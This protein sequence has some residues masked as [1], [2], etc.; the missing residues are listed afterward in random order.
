MWNAHLV[1]LNALLD[2]RRDRQLLELRR[3]LFDI[4]AFLRLGVRGRRV[5]SRE[6]GKKRKILMVSVRRCRVS[7]SH[8]ASM[9][10]D[11]PDPEQKK[12]DVMRQLC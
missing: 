12:C 2:R 3:Y 1:S 5:Q 6:K 7:Q 9:D 4:G 8:R 10:N 11:H